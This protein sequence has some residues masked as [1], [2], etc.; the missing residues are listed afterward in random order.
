MFIHKAGI[1][2]SQLIL[3]LFSVGTAAETW[4]LFLLNDEIPAHGAG[5][6]RPVRRPQ[7]LVDTA[8]VEAVLAWV[9]PPA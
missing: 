4:E 7:P 1:D 9:Q 3:F 5:V 8:V 2:I 6:S